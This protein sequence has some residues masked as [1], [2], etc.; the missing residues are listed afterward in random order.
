MAEKVEV[1]AFVCKDVFDEVLDEGFGEVHVSL[2]VA[3]GYFWL[4]HPEFGCMA[5]GV[6]VFRTECGAE[7]V[8]I[9]EGAGVGFG[10]KLSADGEV[11]GLFKEVFFVGCVALLWVEGGDVEHLARTFAVASRDDGGVYPDE[12]S[13][14]EKPM[15]SAC[16]AVACAEDGSIKV[17]AW[18]EVGYGA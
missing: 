1:S 10:L 9:A 2:K 17:G 11:G 13:F 8:D 14:L 15:D 16:E 12:V 6:G 3:E 18:A 7:G 4:D 5:C